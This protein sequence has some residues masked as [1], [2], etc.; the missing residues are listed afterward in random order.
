MSEHSGNDG[1]IV[2]IGRFE[3][4]PETIEGVRDALLT[5]QEASRAE[6]GC[7]DYTFSVELGDPAIVRLSERWDDEASLLAHFATPHMAEFRAALEG[8]AHWH[9]DVHFFAAAEV[10]R[11]GS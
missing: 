4:T 9:G 3:T 2:V 10:P 7:Q 1:E 6:K 8:Q 5:M 11:P